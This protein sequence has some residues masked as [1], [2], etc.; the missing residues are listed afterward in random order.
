L[1]L[2]ESDSM[3]TASSILITG[4]SSG[5]GAALA[6]AYAAEGVTLALSGRDAARLAET[7]SACR[8]LGA[9]VT[10]ETVD[11]C[12][13]TAMRAW[14]DA[15]DDA[16]PLDLVIANAGISGGTGGTGGE[17]EEQARR[18]IAA[19][20]DGTLNTVHPAL[21]RMKAR[22][23]GQIAVMSSLAGFLGFAGA[24]AYSAAKAAVRIYGEALRGA[25]HEDGIAVSVICPGFVR[26][27]MTATNK[28]KMPLLMDAEKAAGII[29]KGLA[30]NKPRIAFPFPTYFLS[31]F[32]GSLTPALTDP[33]FRMLPKKE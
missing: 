32:F 1:S 4:A 12:D 33:L 10:A 24:P 29:M 15:C 25:L 20:L 23:H 18:I 28:Y 31:W 3:I 2:K 8:E 9:A 27:R 7:A 14:V 30:R 5:I 26:S 19:S 21:E 6:K 22:G 13:R 11:V 16:A 17:S